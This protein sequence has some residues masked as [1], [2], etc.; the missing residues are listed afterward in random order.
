MKVVYILST[1]SIVPT[2]VDCVLVGH[3]NKNYYKCSK[4]NSDTADSGKLVWYNYLV[5]KTCK[6]LWQRDVNAS[7]N[8]MP[9]ASSIRNQDGRPTAFKRV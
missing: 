7:K 5:C 9:I 6:T 3:Y 2:C 8:M 1:K 4:Y